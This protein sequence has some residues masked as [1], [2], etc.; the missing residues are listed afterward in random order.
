[1]I[2]YYRYSPPPFT[3]EELEEDFYYVVFY[4][5]LKLI[6]RRGINPSLSLPFEKGRGRAVDVCIIFKFKKL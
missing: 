3:K 2:K 5:L 6:N 1:M 4:K